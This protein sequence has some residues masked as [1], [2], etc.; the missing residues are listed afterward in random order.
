[1]LDLKRLVLAPII[2]GLIIMGSIVLPFSVEAQCQSAEKL[3]QGIRKVFPKLQFEVKKISPS[4]VSGLCR[5]QVKIGGQIHL[6]YSDSRGDFLFTGNLFETKTG[7]NLTQE[8]TQFLNRFTS[9]EFRQLEPLT[10]FTMG[11]GKKVVYLVTDPQCPFCKQAEALIKKISAKEDLLVRFL[12]FPLDSHKGA[13]EQCVSIL[14]DRK[15]I[16]GFDSGYQSSNQCPEGIKKIDSTIA[17]LQKKGI[18][19]TPTLIFSDGIY[20]SG[21]P[22]EEEL[23]KRLGLSKPN[24]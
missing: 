7:K 9:E 2:I 5:I 10:A 23:R 14:C 18:T 24:H 8:T 3:E 11:Q 12:L 4:E 19:S 17:F 21:L 16:E 22:P 20:I 1:M 15:G 6:L 13:R